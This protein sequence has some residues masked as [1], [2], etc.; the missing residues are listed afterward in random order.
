MDVWLNN[1]RRP[2]E[3]SGTSGQ[4]VVLNGGLN[5]SVL[6]GWWAEAYDG[7][8]GFAIGTGRTHQIRVHLAHVGLP[9]LCDRAYGHRAELTRGDLSGDAGDKTVLLNR[10]ALHA[11]RLRFTHPRSGQLMEIEA[12]LPAD[13]AGVLAELRTYRS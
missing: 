3:A 13:I 1:P 9:V 10:Q 11:Q 8:N 12:P 4:K 2:L 5:L 6:D 7:Q